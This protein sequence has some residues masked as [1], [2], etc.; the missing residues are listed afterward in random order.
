[1]PSTQEVLASLPSQYKALQQV[2]QRWRSLKAGKIP[3]PQVYSTDNTA[4][5]PP[6]YD[7]VIAGG[8][9]G[10]FL[11]A[12]LAQRGLR[13][14]LLERGELR[15]R[16]QEWNTSRA[17]LD[18]FEVLGLL[19]D[20]EI[21]Q[22]IATEYNPA[23]VAF[24]QGAEL[25][26]E[27]VLNIGVDPVYLLAALKEKFLAA[28]GQLLEHTPLQSVTVHP[29]GVQINTPDAPITARLLVDAMG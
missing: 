27:G 23:R 12:A 14:A 21:E 6:D 2:D 22:A 3:V 13:V 4:L 29:D 1:M 28:G 8:T 7:A 19:S 17:E 16:D 15:G 11:G 20:E 18:T 9:L 5:G 26:V 24:H 10:I 25:W